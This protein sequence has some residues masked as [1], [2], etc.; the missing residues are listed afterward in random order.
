MNIRIKYPPDFTEAETR[1]DYEISS[2]MK[3]LWLVELDLL[4]ELRRVLDKYGLTYYADSGTLIGAVRHKGF[5]P[6][7][8]DIDIVIK[9]QDYEKLMEVAPKEFKKPYFFQCVYTDDH[10][11]RGYSRLRNIDSTAVGKSDIY[12][13][14]VH[15]IFIDIFPLDHVPDD[16]EEREQWF[17]KIR[18]MNSLLRCTRYLDLEDE[19]SVQKKLTRPFRILAGAALRV[20]GYERLYRDYLKLCT[21]YNDIETEY[22]SYVA[23]SMGRQRHIWE[24]SCFDETIEVP[25]EFTTIRI[26]KG[27]DSR[28]RTEYGD[29]M[30]IVHAATTHGDLIIEPDIP[31]K[32]YEKTHSRK[33]MWAYLNR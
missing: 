6:W 14:T 30:K 18:K 32:E 9:R 28:L 13:G 4:A 5:I 25:Y 16:P 7:D 8:D 33:D 2:K 29:Y 11:L 31:Y 19:K 22:V 12:S 20:Y 1:C 10:F 15:G 24:R 17:K 3:K 21:K 23:Y 27:Y 26:P